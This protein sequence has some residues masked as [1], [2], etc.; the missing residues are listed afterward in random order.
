MFQK[1]GRTQTMQRPFFKKSIVLASLLTV[2]LWSAQGIAPSCYLPAVWAQTSPQVTRLYQQGV[3]AYSAGQLRDAVRYFSQ[4]GQQD[5]NFSD[6]FFNLGSIQYDQRNYPA[7]VDAFQ[8]VL[9]LNPSDSEARFRLGLS[10][11]KLQQFNEAVNTLRAIPANNSF[12]GQATAKIREI[13]Q[14][15]NGDQPIINNI[16]RQPNTNNPNGGLPNPK[17]DPNLRPNAK[18]S[19]ETYTNG[20]F[21]PTGMAI[22]PDGTIFVANYSKNQICRVSNKGDKTVFV[23]GKDLN[24]P[25]G[26]VRDPRNGSLYVAN[27]LKNN[28]I[29]V[30]QEGQVSVLASGLKKPYNL[31]LDTLTN[32]L[33]VT[34]QETNT[35][36]RIKLSA[37]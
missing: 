33:Y 2:G 23:Q 13:T 34:E 1:I 20:L 17:P 3:E 6:A 19:V 24:G 14:R 7:A 9:G 11:D 16:A 18:F 28:I 25:I 30:D 22:T 36:S 37:G 27:Y 26:L 4:A 8:R 21:G 31:L 10:Y 12:Y 5:P 35:I 32:T 29:R 15:A